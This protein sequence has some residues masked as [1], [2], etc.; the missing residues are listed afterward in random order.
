MAV[1]APGYTRPKQ[2]APLAPLKEQMISTACPGSTVAAWT[3]APHVHEFW[4]PWIRTAMA[5]AT[6]Q[7]VR[8]A[9]SS[10]G[11]ITALAIHA[12][13]TG[14]VSRVLHVAADPV[15]PTRNILT[16]SHTPE[17]LINGAG[18]RYAASS[19]LTEIDDA[20]SAEGQFLFI[21]K[22]C[23]VS[24]LRQLATVDPRVDR[25]VPLMLSF[26]CAGMPSHAG[27][28]AIIRE[29]GLN[30]A[31][32]TGFRFRGNGWPG[33]TVA[34][35]RDGSRGEMRYA[36]SWGRHLS[37]CVQARCKICPDGVGGVADVAC[38]DAWYG[39]ET[40]Y[41]QFEEQDGRSLTLAR[42]PAGAALLATAEQAGRV[43][44]S[45]L[46][47]DQIDLMQPGQVRR[48]RALR[49]R[50]AG[51]RFIGKPVPVMV[52]LR[53]VEAGRRAPRREAFRNFIGIIRR[54]LGR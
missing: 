10:G 33:L 41:P 36:D 46:D 1:E 18:S 28:D 40:G 43:V 24:A 44:S 6:D 54:R 51:L 23:D 29:M 7:Q 13:E 50:I 2:I 31:D 38:A 14:L 22:P 16:W 8:F 21:G 17:D 9:G 32:V 42:T 30:P 19:P 3:E 45:A 25:K 48:K 52:G 12:L 4:G 53:I 49:A 35:T 26:F 15:H 34:E 39:G 5:Y 47:V 27:A 37:S 11:V 20:L